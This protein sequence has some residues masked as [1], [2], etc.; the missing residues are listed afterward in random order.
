[1]ICD[2]LGM[3]LAIFVVVGGRWTVVD[4]LWQWIGE[5][6]SR[7]MVIDESIP[8]RELHDRIFEKF[9]INKEEF[10]LKLSF[11]PKSRQRIWPSYVMDDEDVEA[12]LLGRTKNTIETTL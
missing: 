9:G 11:V 7:L 12:F 8:L 10:N 6:E 2:F 3:S 4:G 1:M 5:E